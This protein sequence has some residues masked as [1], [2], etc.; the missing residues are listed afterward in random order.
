LIFI[1]NFKIIFFFLNKKAPE[2]LEAKEYDGKADVWSVGCIYYEM[3]VGKAPFNG[4][5]E[6]DL[7]INIHKTSFKIPDKVNIST[8][9]VQVLTK[10]SCIL[11]YQMF[12]QI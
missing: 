5:S 6:I 8:S 4:R 9:S 1:K 11:N 3:L 12:I 7:L 10:V 2:V